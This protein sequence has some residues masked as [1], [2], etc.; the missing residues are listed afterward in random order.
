[1]PH[2]TKKNN[3]AKRLKKK[4]KRAELLPSSD[5]QQ[6]RVEKRYK[7]HHSNPHHP[8]LSG[9][10]EPPKITSKHQSYLEIVP[11]PNKKKHIDIVFSN[12]PD[13]PPHY[14]L[15]PAGNAQ[16]TKACMEASREQG[17]QMIIITVSSTFEATLKDM[18]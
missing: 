18:G 5:D 10:K 13:P 15:V 11:N 12:N 4:R 1:M 9:R 17:A 8:Y 6:Y 14:T 2:N 7:P 3:E 16:F